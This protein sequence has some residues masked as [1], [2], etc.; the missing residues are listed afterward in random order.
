MAHR[1]QR[2]LVRQRTELKRENARLPGSV[3]LRHPEEHVAAPDVGRCIDRAPRAEAVRLRARRGHETFNRQRRAGRQLCV[4]PA[5][6]D[7]VLFDDI[8]AAALGHFRH[9]DPLVVVLHR[10]DIAKRVIRARSRNV[11]SRKDSLEA[12]EPRTRK[13]RPWN[14]ALDTK[15]EPIRAGLAVHL[16]Q[17]AEQVAV[18]DRGRIAQHIHP[19]HDF[20]RQVDRRGAGGRIADVETVQNKRRLMC[21]R[22]AQLHQAI[23]PS[24]DRRQQRQRLA[25]LHVGRWQSC[26]GVGA[27]FG[28]EQR[29]R[30]RCRAFRRRDDGGGFRRPRDE[31]HDARRVLA[32]H[33][34]LFESVERDSDRVAWDLGVDDEGP[35]GFRR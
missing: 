6:H 17:S 20:D 5:E 34:C 32:R 1:R 12:A 22:A 26:D 27:Q 9:G 23:R 3:P 35:V 25:R 31:Q 24:N 16:H 14:E 29:R 11:G 4:H 21:A 19:A 15:R 8:R 33:L 30:G 28:T 13:T 10:G 7:G 18:T 2:G